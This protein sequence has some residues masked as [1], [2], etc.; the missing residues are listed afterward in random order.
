MLVSLEW[1]YSDST[2]VNKII[3]LQSSATQLLYPFVKANDGTV[4]QR[5][6]LHVL[7]GKDTTYYA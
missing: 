6:S 1:T 4:S 2:V 5:V 7:A 3:N